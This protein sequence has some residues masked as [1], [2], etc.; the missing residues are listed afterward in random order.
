MSSAGSDPGPAQPAAPPVCHVSAQSGYD[1][2]AA[3]YDTEDNPLVLLEAPEVARQL[4]DVRGL[5]ALD[6]GCG[7][8]RHALQLAAGGARVTALDFSAAMLAQARAK[9]GAGR[10]RFV[11]HD[12]AE[13]FPLPDAAFDCVVSGLVLEHI[14]DLH[15]LFRELRRVCRP[16]G[17]IV[18]SAMHPAMMLR[19]ITAR[20]TDPQTG[21]ETRPR[22]HPHQI[23]DFVLAALRS[24][25]RIEHLGEHAV[26]EA[27][28]GRCPRAQKYLHWPMLFLM[29]LRS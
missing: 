28:A 22:S 16:D 27:L 19:G 10:V 8:G 23:S 17:R 14:A 2:W 11:Q 25:A 9:P 26:D 15:P 1:R 4:G 6:V 13:A 29:T 24:G 18:V 3:I 21:L 20:F 7:T 5:D 12:L